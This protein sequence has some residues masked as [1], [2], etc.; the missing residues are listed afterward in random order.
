MINSKDLQAK[1]RE[2]VVGLITEPD[3][4]L[5]F[6]QAWLGGFHQ[7]S[8]YNMLLILWQFP[9]STICAGFHKWQSLGRFVKKGSKA[10]WILA[11]HIIRETFQ[12]VVDGKEEEKTREKLVGFR[13][14]Y[15]FDY[16]QTDGKELNI[17]NTK[18]K[19]KPSF[20][21]DHIKSKFPEIIFN[22]SQGIEDGKVYRK[23]QEGTERVFVDISSRE[24]E[25]QMVA[26]L[27]HELAHFT[28][29]HLD[30]RTSDKLPRNVMEIEA[31]SVAYIVCSMIDIDNEGSKYYIADWGGR[32]QI[33]SDQSM[34]ILKA[35][36]KILR[37]I[38]PDK[39][40]KLEDI[41]VGGEI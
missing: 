2:L 29:G 3:K 23:L 15:V 10:I 8:L 22:V 12:A 13:Q 19:G 41:Q 7:Y 24:N 18:V 14:V 5:A 32:E 38:E 25:S 20:S 16:S 6:R 11:P 27:V 36:E 9:K 37:R 34:R 35:T 39:F 21:M 26:S 1:L 4:L 30:L 28:L 40:S 31:E 17:G 33:I